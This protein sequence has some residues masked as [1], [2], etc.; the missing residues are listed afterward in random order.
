MIL[1]GFVSPEL[2]RDIFSSRNLVIVSGTSS[3]FHLL[4]HQPLD[5]TIKNWFWWNHKQVTPL[6]DI[7]HFRQFNWC[8]LFLLKFYA[9]ASYLRSR[10]CPNNAHAF[11]K[12]TSRMQIT[13]DWWC[14]CGRIISN[15]V[16]LMD[17]S[18]LPWITD[19]WAGTTFNLILIRSIFHPIST[20][21]N[22]WLRWLLLIQ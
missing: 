21:K 4:L 2:K 18:S 15:G 1:F 14:W 12:A 7:R 9:N 6:V 13:W 11:Y 8:D 22:D 10:A 5:L 19:W 3:S 16:I 17:F 20:M